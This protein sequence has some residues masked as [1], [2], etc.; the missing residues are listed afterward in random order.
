MLEIIFKFDII[1]KYIFMKIINKRFI[2]RFIKSERLVN[3]N[4]A[5]SFMEN[6]V[7]K[8]LKKKKMRL[9]GLEH[10][11]LLLLAD[12]LPLKKSPTKYTNF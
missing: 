10:P 8:I 1:L 4:D 5:I 9:F 11:S 3:Y 2:I 7:E 6:R 12:L